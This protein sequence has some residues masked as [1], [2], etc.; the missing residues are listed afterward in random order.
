MFKIPSDEI[1]VI[2][3]IAGAHMGSVNKLTILSNYVVKTKA[4]AIKFQFFK[5][6]ELLTP[7]HPEHLLFKRLEF[8]DY[9]W[10]TLFK[11][12]K[13]TGLK[14][15]A[16]V[17]S[18]NR[19]KFANTLG[20]DAFKIHSSDIN[21]LELIEYVAKTQ[22]PILL[23]CSGCRL[24]EIDDAVNLI[25]G[26]S[27]SQIILMH[28]FQGFPTDVSQINLRR[29]HSLKERYNFQVG[30]SDHIDGD[31]ELAVYMP[32]IAAGFGA[33][34][35]EK[36]I[37]LNRALKEEDYQSSLTPQEFTKMVRLLK[38][39][40]KS[41]GNSS[42][43]I[44]GNELKYRKNMK[45]V[46]VAKRDLK[47][48]HRIRRSDIVYRRVSDSPSDSP[49]LI[50][51]S[52]TR[53]FIKKHS[54]LTNENL[55]LKRSK[56]VAAIACRVQSSRL[57]GKPLQL[58]GNKSILDNIIIQL[59]QSK[60]IDDIVLA[61]SERAGNEIFSEFA[62]K[63]NLKF[64]KGNDRDV[65]KRLILAAEHVNAQI[66]FRI[67]SED[68][69]IYWEII[70]DAISQ[71]IKSKADFTYTPDLPDGIGFEIIGLG[72][73]KK[74]HE[75]GDAR[76]RSELVTEY[77]FRRKNQFKIRPFNVKPH[78]R[79]HDLRL[80]VDYP[81]DLILVRSIMSKIPK[82]DLPRY[83]VILK[84][85]DKNSKLKEINQK[86]VLKSYRNWL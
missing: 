45:K 14:I 16:D 22:K 30:Y 76:S 81:E 78:L 50:I 72:A 20:V 2:A 56:V 65:L 25:K 62:R 83:E 42:F 5:A 19:A 70:D 74:S 37:T 44:S 53:K 36:H 46:P 64:I 10:K 31:S 6:D 52:S 11:R 75:K 38:E 17:F 58:V 71:H 66:L 47:S 24:N 84:I 57:F 41:F 9:Q 55:E 4:D 48:G 32:L 63:N 69:F 85:I 13:V 43:D 21:N 12:L 26:T 27:D 35:I 77:I 61:I 29:I 3:E 8:A 80:T 86:Y 23:S 67:T 40:Q 15:L 54:P 59:K 34:I 51:G 28:G 18:L 33:T 82:K 49:D 79:R 73:L 1:F 7:D 60:M 39:A 68:P